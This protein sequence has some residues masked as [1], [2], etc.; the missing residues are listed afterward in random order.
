MI[1]DIISRY[2]NKN[3]FLPNPGFASAD[4]AGPDT[5]EEYKKNLKIQP[6]DWF[7]RT[8]KIKYKLNKNLYRADEFKNIDWANSVVVFGCS[9][10]FGVGVDDAHTIPK[11]LSD[12]INMP[13]INMGIGGVSNSYILY[14]STILAEGYPAPKAIIHCWTGM[15]RTTY[16]NNYYL[17]SFGS[18]ISDSPYYNEWLKSDQHAKVETLMASKIS[19]QIWKD[20]APYYECS[21]FDDTVKLLKCD[22]PQKRLFT[23]K[24][25]DMMH[26]GPHA[27]E[28]IAGNISKKILKLIN[29]N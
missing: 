12:K 7:Y 27:C 24:A 8:A 23:D 14:N 5:S 15:H 22:M 6:E 18:W 4:W 1:F 11:F 25:R 9:H 28:H 2:I 16:F 3:N 10:I 29:D 13:V 26:F 21:H 20:R 19:R 17:V